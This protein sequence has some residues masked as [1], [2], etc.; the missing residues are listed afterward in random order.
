MHVSLVLV[1]LL[2]H[3]ELHACYR[4][5]NA[6]DPSRILRTV[7]SISCLLALHAMALRRGQ[8][9]SSYGDIL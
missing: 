4:A 5:A 3:T 7:S 2:R 1:C 8:S 6:I 9:E